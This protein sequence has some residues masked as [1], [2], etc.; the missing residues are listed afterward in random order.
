MNTLLIKPLLEWSGI[1]AFY[2][3]VI[4]TQSYLFDGLL[5]NIR[6]VELKLTHETKVGIN[7][8]DRVQSLLTLYRQATLSSNHLNW[9]PHQFL[10]PLPHRA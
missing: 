8:V 4:D 2:N 5:H 6:E 7:I 1:E 9:A 3:R 10:I